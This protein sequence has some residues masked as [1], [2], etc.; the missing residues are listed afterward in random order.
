MSR[1]PRPVMRSDG[2]LYASMSEAAA[3][4]NCAPSSIFAACR[5]SFRRVCGYGW[6]YVEEPACDPEIPEEES[7]PLYALYRGDEFL[8][9]GTLEEVAKWQGI[10]MGTV[11]YAASPS[12]IK[13]AGSGKRLVAVRV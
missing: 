2:K 8:C 11:R 7:I 10:S 6:S 9:L 12:N 3:D 5:Q 13:R 1:R 4:M